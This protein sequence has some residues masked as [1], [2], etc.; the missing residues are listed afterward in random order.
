[1]QSQ[2]EE[3]KEETINILLVGTRRLLV[4]ETMVPMK[5]KRASSF[6]LVCFVVVILVVVNALPTIFFSILSTETEP[7][8][9]VQRLVYRVSTHIR[10]V[11]CHIS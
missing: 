11:M 7:E 2:P 8:P 6:L 3:Q 5:D 9:E 1:M 4:N 10:L